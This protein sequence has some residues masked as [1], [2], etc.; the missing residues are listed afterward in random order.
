MHG[1]FASLGISRIILISLVVF[2]Q[3]LLAYSVAIELQEGL[4]DYSGSSD[5]Y[6]GLDPDQN[7]GSDEQLI[8][9]RSLGTTPSIALIRFPIFK[10]EGGPLPNNLPNLSGELALYKS[11]TNM[12]TGQ[13]FEL[14]TLLTPWNEYEVTAENASD[15]QPWTTERALSLGNDVS[16]NLAGT[17]NVSWNPGWL[18]FNVYSS[19]RSFSKG[20]Q[21]NNGWH[22]VNYDGSLD[23]K[24][25][26]GKEYLADVSRRPKVHIYYSLDENP[27][28]EVQEILSCGLIAA[29]DQL[30]LAALLNTDKLVIQK[31]EY[32]NGSEKI[33]ESTQAPFIGSWENIPPGQHSITAKA[34][35]W[36]GADIISPPMTVNVEPTR[37][38]LLPIEVTPAENSPAIAGPYYVRQTLQDGLLGYAG[39]QDATL[40][41]N[42]P[43][44]N[45][46]GEDLIWGDG[47]RPLIQFKLKKSEGG[48]IPDSAVITGGSLSLYA[49]SSRNEYH[50]F[51]IL[52]LNK[53][54]QED[55][56]SWSHANPNES[57][58]NNY[59]PK[60]FGKD[61]YP[62]EN[63]HGIIEHFPGW[64]EF[65]VSNSLLAFEQGD[66]N[67]GWAFDRI[68]GSRYSTDIVSSEALDNNLPSINRPKLS[69]DYYL[70]T[71][72][73]VSVKHQD[74]CEYFGVG[75]N[76][77][78]STS[79]D[80]N[81]VTI[82]KVEYF[83]NSDKIGES[84]HA[85]FRSIWKNLPAG[86]HEVTAHVSIVGGA[87][88]SGQLIVAVAEANS[89]PSVSLSSHSEGATVSIGKTEILS[90]NALDSDG[91]I[92][93]VEFFASGNKIDEATQAPY[94]TEWTPETLGATD[95]LVT[96]TDDAGDTSSSSLTLNVLPPNAPPTVNFSN[97]TNGVRFLQGQS[98]TI[99]VEASD[100]DGEVKAVEF[101]IDNT[102][103]DD[104]DE[105]PYELEWTGIPVGSFQLS[106][107]AIDS[108]DDSNTSTINVIVQPLFSIAAP[109]DGSSVTIGET[110]PIVVDANDPS[111][112][113]VEFFAG[114]SLLSQKSDAPYS[115]D[116][117]PSSQGNQS[118]TALVHFAGAAT[119]SESISVF[120]NTKPEIS[121]TEIVDGYEV[122]DHINLNLLVNVTDADGDSLTVDYYLNG[123]RI[124]ANSTAPYTGRWTD[125]QEG[126]YTLEA[127]A[128]DARGA[129]NS[130]AANVIVNHYNLIP[131][132]ALNPM[133]PSYAQG[134]ELGVSANA[135][136][137]H[138]AVKKVEFF[139][140]EQKIDEDFS[141]PYSVKWNP[142][143]GEYELWAIV[144]DFEGA[145]SDSR[146]IHRHFVEITG[147][148]LPPTISF[149]IAPDKQVFFEGDDVRLIANAS[150]PDL[151][152]FVESVE[153]SA[154]TVP[155]NG[156]H[157]AGTHVH[158]QT[159]GQE[160]FEYFWQDLKPGNYVVDATAY[161]NE[162]GKTEAISIEFAVSNMQL[163]AV[164][165]FDPSAGATLIV[166]QTV[167]LTASASDPDGEIVRVE[168]FIDD[169]YVGLSSEEA[170]WAYPWT[171][172]S[173]GTFELHAVAVDDQNFT[174][175]SERVQFTVEDIPRIEPTIAITNPLY[176]AEV[177]VDETIRIVASAMDD[178]TIS[179][180]V[181]F[182]DGEEIDTV[183]TEPYETTWMTSASGGYHFTAI[184]HDN[185]GL[186]K[187][188][189]PVL[190]NVAPPVGS[191]N[192]SDCY[193]VDSESPCAVEVHWTA[194]YAEEPT[195]VIYKD[196]TE[197]IEN[198]LRFSE[199]TNGTV[200]AVTDVQGRRYVL[201]SKPGGV[202]LASLNLYGKVD[203]VSLSADKD[204]CEVGANES[205]NI[206]ITWANIC[207]FGNCEPVEKLCLFNDQV[208][209]HCVEADINGVINAS[210]LITVN[211][212]SDTRHFSI[213]ASEDSLIDMA[214]FSIPFV[215]VA[216]G[217]ITIIADGQDPDTT[218]YYC[219]ADE[220]L[221]EIS[222]NVEVIDLP[223]YATACL[224][225]KTKDSENLIK[226]F[227]TVESGSVQVTPTAS[228]LI[229]REGNTQNDRVMAR[230]QL[231]AKLPAF[232]GIE[233]QLVE[234]CS[235]SLSEES[236]LTKIR[237]PVDFGTYCL[238]AGETNLSCSGELSVPASREGISYDLRSGNSL[239]SPL[240][241]SKTFYAQPVYPNELL[242]TPE[243]CHIS[244]APLS[245]SVEVQWFSN[246]DSE[247]CLFVD[248]ELYT[249][250]GQE[251]IFYGS[252]LFD[253]DL[254]TEEKPST[255]F[256]LRAGNAVD[257]ATDPL[258]IKEVAA[259]TNLEFDLLASFLQD[260]DGNCYL[261][262]QNDCEIVLNW[263]TN[264]TGVDIC[265]GYVNESMHWTNLSCNND[266][267]LS[268]TGFRD[269]QK[270]GVIEYE[271]RA[272][273][274]DEYV[275]LMTYSVT[276]AEAAFDIAVEED[277]S[278]EVFQGQICSRTIH[279]DSINDQTL[280][281]FD[282]ENLHGLPLGYGVNG[283]WVSLGVGTH[284]LQLGFFNED[285]ETRTY[286]GDKITINVNQVDEVSPPLP[287]KYNT[288]QITSQPYADI[289]TTVSTVYD[290]DGDNKE[291]IAV[292]VGS[293]NSGTEFIA[294]G[295]GGSGSTSSHFTP[296]T[297]PSVTAGQTIPGGA[298]PG[299]VDVTNNGA[300]T[301]SIPI[302]VAKGGAGM[303]PSLALSY[304][305]SAGNGIAGIG[306]DVNAI[307]MITDCAQVFAL[308]NQ[309]NPTGRYC[310]NG[311]RLSHVS[312]N[313][314]R[315]EAETFS[316]II[317]SA[318]QWQVFYKS[319]EVATFGGSGYQL[320]RENG[321]N[322]WLLKM[323]Q[324][325]IAYNKGSTTENIRQY[326]YSID[327]TMGEILLNR[328]SYPGGY[329][330][331]VYGDRTDAQYGYDLGY[332][333]AQT[334]LLGRIE[335]YAEGDL[336][337]G[338]T[339][340]G[341]EENPSEKTGFM[342]LANVQQCGSDGSCV[343]KTTF[344]WT[345]GWIEANQTT[346]TVDASSTVYDKNSIHYTDFDGNGV[347]E[348]VYLS[349]HKWWVKFPNRSEALPINL[350]SSVI[351]SSRFTD[352][353]GD[354]RTDLMFPDK[355]SPYRFV[356]W[357]IENEQFIYRESANLPD[358]TGYQNFFFA[359]MN[360]DGLQD[361]LLDLD[362]KVSMRLN[363]GGDF[364]A[365][366]IITSYTSGSAPVYENLAKALVIDFEGD[367]KQEI[368]LPQDG[369]TLLISF[370]GTNFSDRSILP[371]EIDGHNRLVDFNGDGLKDLVEVKKVGS[372][373]EI[374]VAWNTG[375]AFQPLQPTGQRAKNLTGMHG[376]YQDFD[377]KEGMYFL[378][379]EVLQEANSTQSAVYEHTRKYLR[380]TPAT[381]TFE[382]ISLGGQ[383]ENSF[384]SQIAQ[385]EWTADLNGDG[386]RDEITRECVHFAPS[387]GS[388][389]NDSQCDSVKL[390]LSLS[391]VDNTIT[392]PG[393]VDYLRKIDNGQ[394]LSYEVTFE[395]KNE[396]RAGAYPVIP[397]NYAVTTVGSLRFLVNGE[398]Q[399][400]QQYT[401]AGL[402]VHASGL[403][404]L[405]YQTVTKESNKGDVT[406]TTVSE[407]SQDYENFKHQR[408]ERQ[409]VTVKK[410]TVEQTI[411]ELE[412]TYQTALRGTEGTDAFGWYTYLDTSTLKEWELD[413]SQK[414]T[415]LT[416]YTPDVEAAG[417]QYSHDNVNTVG[418]MKTTVTTVTS[419]GES[420]RVTTNNWY[421]EDRLS[422]W[423]L[424]RLTK[425]TTKSEA[426]VN[427][428][429]S[430]ITKASSWAYH[431]NG[432][433]YSESILEGETPVVTTTYGYNSIG[434]KTSETTADIATG[435][436]R[437]STYEWD[438]LGRF[439]IAV[440][441]QLQ[442]RVETTYH[443]IFGTKV[444]EVDALGNQATWT[445][446]GFGRP[447]QSTSP[448]GVVTTTTFLDKSP[449]D[450]DHTHYKIRTTDTLN[451]W[452]EKLFDVQG[453]VI[454][455]R[456]QNGLGAKVAVRT[457]YGEHG[458]ILKKY[459]PFAVGTT[460]QYWTQYQDYDAAMRARKVVNP[461]GNSATV[462]YTANGVTYVNER[463]HQ[464]QELFY[465]NGKLKQTVDEDNNLV[466][467]FYDAT[468]NLVE[469]NAAG[470]TTNVYYDTLGRKIK[471][472]DPNKG[473]WE[474]RY[475]GFGELVGQ[476]D[477]NG[478]VT[479]QTYDLLG[480]M[481]LRYDNYGTGH[482]HTIEEDACGAPGNDAFATRWQYDTA[483]YGVGQL[484]RVS[485]DNGT[486]TTLEYDGMGRV[487]A[488]IKTVDNETF[489]SRSEYDDLGRVMRSVY[490]SG[491]AIRN[492]YNQYSTLSKVTEDD[493]ATRLWELVDM[494]I[495]GNV[496]TERLAEGGILTRDFTY[497]PE[498]G[499][500]ESI[501][502]SSFGNTADL[503][504]D[505]VV[506]DAV[507]NLDYR[508]DIV[509]GAYENATYD[510]LNRL[511][512]ISY[513]KGPDSAPKP[514]VFTMAESDFAKYG[515]YSQNK[516]GTVTVSDEGR[517]VELQGNI[518]KSLAINYKV[519]ADTVLEFEFSTDS[520]G[521]IHAIGLDQDYKVSESRL[522]QLEGTETWG[523]Q[524]FHNYEVGT[525]SKFYRIPVGEY[526]TGR[527]YRLVFTMD[528]DIDNPTGSSVFKNIRIYEH[529]VE[530]GTTGTESMQYEANGNIKRKWNNGST[531]YGYGGTAC[532]RQAGPH[533]VTAANGE[534]YCYDAN[535]S[536]TSGA[537]RTIT[538][539]D[540]GKPIRIERGNTAVEFL[541]GPNRSRV[542][543]VDTKDGKTTKTYYAGSYE[544][545][546]L[547]SGVI[548]E[549]HYIGG[550][551]V[552]TKKSSS[553]ALQKAF[554]LKDH[555]G[556]VAAYV[557]IAKLAANDPSA[558]ERSSFD[559]WGQRRAANWDDFDSATLL[560]YQ[561][562]YSP[563]GYTGHE[564]LD[565]LGLIHMNGRVYDPLL[566]RFLSADPFIQDPKN[567]QSYNRY[568]Y[569]WNN[570]LSSTDPSGYFSVKDLVGSAIVDPGLTAMLGTQ[571]YMA[572]K[573][574]KE[575]GRFA[576]K[577]KYV[578]QAVQIIG[579]IATAKAGPGPCAA[580]TAAVTYGVTD[581]DMRASVRAGAV[582]Y[583]QAY[584]AAQV[585]KAPLNE[586]EAVFAHGAVGFM[587]A[588]FAGGDPR[589][590]F[591]SAVAGKSFMLGMNEIGGFEAMGL[592]TP[593]DENLHLMAGRTAIV[594]GVGGTISK[595]SGGS[596]ANGAV[597]A[598]M[599]H[600]FNAELAQ[601]AQGK[602]AEAKLLKELRGMG[603]EVAEQ[604]YLKLFPK[605]G[606]AEIT[607][608]ADFA[609]LKDGV[610]VFGEIKDGMGA[611]LTPN[612]KVV[613]HALIVGERVGFVNPQVM[614]RI[615]VM[616]GVTYKIG[617]SMFTY[618]NSR[619][620]RQ[621]GRRWVGRGLAG[622]VTI[623][624]SSAALGAELLFHS[625]AVG[626]NS[627][628]PGC[629]NP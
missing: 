344:A 8:I 225:H 220:N 183:T 336:L 293:G 184:A 274:Q 302:S 572:D 285:G 92:S 303:A 324:D 31:I 589:N 560:D 514:P 146:G 283:D 50:E 505:F 66:P 396:V 3:K 462:S 554:M 238:F 160:V 307:E 607:A 629:I 195:L 6:M 493:N 56:V 167:D 196:S 606:V 511:E 391:G 288:S 602:A 348:I 598:A 5:A 87:D 251:A 502:T 316:R 236:C 362:G 106:A 213:R 581:G 171:P 562:E 622:A 27:E 591:I 466:E 330:N 91:S 61:L 130:V 484:H 516:S 223:L 192:G 267:G 393:P 597:T 305:S 211:Y 241:V 585:S 347:L 175:E 441:N 10:A 204:R 242:V 230:A 109:V 503:Q 513:Q 349:N 323:V 400:S 295:S 510:S 75:G 615:G 415:T 129:T 518:W 392:Y 536:M 429:T 246:V 608:I 531:S 398:E 507:G 490:P 275:V 203:G 444:R 83:L 626:P 483:T 188:S 299:Q 284:I 372:E 578:A 435:E 521:E 449:S 298:V 201:K 243:S 627:D 341:Y 249:C 542:K 245:C 394:G 112:T 199:S 357:D 617:L 364:S 164:T 113:N 166:D 63:P 573:T 325:R 90:A 352:V 322:T 338:S 205:C 296:V 452:S 461:E 20:E 312:G 576:R 111:I 319:G 67:N 270:A 42:T 619:A 132:V 457:E 227:E 499:R 33:A 610:I 442:H 151:Q 465:A 231:Y 541:Y 526:Y 409:T 375:K 119:A 395:R 59:H 570:P 433:L 374:Y 186:T 135:N 70:D 58:W 99:L 191:L 422:D 282:A 64:L 551:A 371:F 454:E 497:T 148:N 335:S 97:L 320:A 439:V 574:L 360:G 100:S 492:H 410:G 26:H 234:N 34:T 81:D 614:A 334:K 359:D 278:C 156:N 523:V 567:L 25:F 326:H 599:Q 317:K 544:Q 332:T 149:S 115:I 525:G 496:L 49:D 416:E 161:D 163:P 291:D 434:L 504:S 417:N 240:V 616:P 512:S 140:N 212:Q 48:M 475:N 69:V 80:T 216:S 226:C 272:I 580:I 96:A 260:A 262:S 470:I 198:T 308:D 200:N 233:I 86:H 532:G 103:V 543:R 126:T 182:E 181:F 464:R 194:S 590:G 121:F 548:E 259:T 51:D 154:T 428:E 427:G 609:Y 127:I 85:P 491:F 304:S 488:S 143:R 368:L 165:V 586:F 134:I 162:T 369:E 180:V 250:K 105:A 468:G 351:R 136:D 625:S 498:M 19:L 527:M 152:G 463:G 515:G 210:K 366:A 524:T 443:P 168:Y 361:M 72:P 380:Y 378:A 556:S 32:F 123:N 68:R 568:A 177:A 104:D 603:Y 173:H 280:F 53:S 533:T 218:S 565:S 546:H 377:W 253:I 621:I 508:Q 399:S 494:D 451:G 383:T 311:Q 273:Y 40:V 16:T 601:H 611:K 7:Y 318:S 501:N 346:D 237:W 430:T 159:P 404:S 339:I 506:W 553:P 297:S 256:T 509:T 221:C 331:F 604:V 107:K 356:S 74:D 125:T 386:I 98:Y 128:T 13:D 176:G 286:V 612:Q 23:A 519:T 79:V 425:A 564:Q 495:R 93:K 235:V 550:F 328:I 287:S 24:I 94:E 78:L 595:L 217:E 52:R 445:Y 77:E 563:R 2:S 102:K 628:C 623:L 555:L 447:Y 593:G 381:S 387:T 437:Q 552:Y 269:L 534:T 397:V 268:L 144:H 30:D 142:T 592:G 281:I 131:H 600:L 478:K 575:F 384:M 421:D 207:H 587:S 354:G 530:A 116:W 423:T 206:T 566:G 559:A 456:A 44:G 101:Y 309:V 147:P 1:R 440:E 133:S 479:C 76:A 469:T 153:F 263:S 301:Y 310:L 408:L 9:N 150:D 426:T 155:Y 340:L 248:D 487:T 486:S 605:V 528:H 345:D 169:E 228:E 549:K 62:S 403:G 365:N 190:V 244:G 138:G 529:T 247:V 264:I 60:F 420:Y 471:M 36:G 266:Q 57:W 538:W 337:L 89:A 413:D 446:D 300:L 389:I 202:E 29:G 185:L 88:L 545:V 582:A 17:A 84:E 583:V 477:A 170:P 314:Y 73:V 547:P 37:G 569:V 82:E 376:G 46:N 579:C 137:F 38:S 473:T 197:E 412:N 45:L 122:N 557:D 258:L 401:F 388:T 289:S 476:K 482:W 41:E 229:L 292:K 157:L 358:A 558:V 139:A 43:N 219:L 343:E 537:G 489:V 189:D 118:L 214:T 35:I 618:T 594:A 315:T 522:F 15:G 480:R 120:G 28:L 411:S 4:N 215:K 373:E 333:T 418:N 255:I 239:E 313:E 12:R 353:D 108:R 117:K 39:T 385:H 436:T 448:N 327:E 450:P 124:D 95:I 71:T 277:L 158:Q 174:R 561:S 453:N 355:D 458:E 624:G 254:P 432:Q 22:I 596:F 47:F 405:G 114:D 455:T 414:P 276:V 485:D 21:I 257:P 481:V 588:G 321:R 460:P 474:Y 193:M 613:Y 382:S 54:W 329:V 279:W 224:W 178:G 306:W 459:E 438:T 539:A 232:N 271:L 535:G 208:L 14:R 265:V 370:D 110:T 402:S 11:N 500:M 18:Y 141:E 517:Q 367:G 379:T 261:N 252:S 222:Y 342:R 187:A 55:S 363:V 520:L 407:F 571:T 350:L 390:H 406:S 65:D 172:R 424:G 419:P 431:S 294:F 467:M 472:D 577:N 584:M 290:F 540:F 145:T 620:M 209:E 179:K